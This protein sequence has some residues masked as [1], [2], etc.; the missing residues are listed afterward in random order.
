M[1]LFTMPLPWCAH[2]PLLLHY[3]LLLLTFAKRAP[4]VGSEAGAEA[5]GLGRFK[6][7]GFLR[8]GGNRNR[9]PQ[10]QRFCGIPV[11]KNAPGQMNCPYAKVLPAAKR[12]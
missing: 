1:L 9:V 7:I 2:Y 5:P 3:S 4:G 12:L 11:I 6:E 10:K 8:E